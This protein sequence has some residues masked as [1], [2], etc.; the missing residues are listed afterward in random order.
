MVNKGLLR[1]Y[2]WRGTLGWGVGRPAI[3]NPGYGEKKNGNLSV[4]PP[5]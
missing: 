1:P 5:N 2:I 4:S 3:M